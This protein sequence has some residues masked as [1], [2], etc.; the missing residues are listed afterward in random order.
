[1]IHEKSMI[2]KFLEVL[3]PNVKIYLF[4]S[5]ARGNHT[6]SSDI[7]LA[8]DVGHTISSL[9]IERAKNTLSA[10]NIPQKIDIVDLHTIPNDLRTT[11]LKEGILWKN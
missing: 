1:M 3:F 7:D 11:I 4:G 10:L 8:L 9:E 6:E 5:R 2:I